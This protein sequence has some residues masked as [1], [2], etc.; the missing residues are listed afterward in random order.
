MANPEQRMESMV[1]NIPERTGKSVEEW[2]ALIQ[3][4][5]RSRVDLGLRLP[6]TAAA[7][8][9]QEAGSFGSGSTSHRV[10]LSSVEEVDQEIEG[11]IRQAYEARG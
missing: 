9:L 1:R 2:V 8:R 4:S 3:A 10:A 5:T 11:W 6:G 7:G